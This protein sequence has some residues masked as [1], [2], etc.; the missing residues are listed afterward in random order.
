MIRRLIATWFALVC[1]AALGGAANAA[2]IELFAIRD[3]TLFEDEQG[4]TSNGSGPSL[5]AGRNS[6]GRARRALVAFDVASAL[7]VASTLDSVTLHLRLS[8]SSDPEPRIVR[9]HRVLAAW[10]EGASF[11]EGGRGAPAAPGDAT[12]RHRFYPTDLWSG[13]GGDFAAAPS[14]TVTVAG[15]GEYRWRGATLTGDVRAWMERPGGAH[16]WIVIAE[17][18]LS[19]TAR[20]FESRESVA[21]EH[22]PRLVLHYS[23]G[24]PTDP[25]TWGRVKALCRK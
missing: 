22:R 11:S 6:Q 20:R 21:V 19:G 18:D 12:W 4:D 25:S 16:G 3:N 8:S 7:P 23:L 17:E 9:L 13:A 5:F 14:G 15:E 1:C 2:E 10:G 24:T